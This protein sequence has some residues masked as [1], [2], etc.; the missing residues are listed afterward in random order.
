MAGLDSRVCMAGLI[1]RVCPR[2]TKCGAVDS[3]GDHNLGGG[4]TFVIG[5]ACRMIKLIS[6][7]FDS[8]CNT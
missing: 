4:V 8:L 6:R 7:V 5:P 3:S 1:S 2:G